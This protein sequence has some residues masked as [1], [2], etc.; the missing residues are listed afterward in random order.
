MEIWFN[1]RNATTLH[2]NEKDADPTAHNATGFRE[3]E[4]NLPGKCLDVHP[5]PRLPTSPAE[6]ESASGSRSS[7][8][9]N[10]SNCHFICCLRHLTRHK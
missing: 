9:H 10:H 5:D 1:Y 7:H 6:C 3:A 8:L 4:R 2:S